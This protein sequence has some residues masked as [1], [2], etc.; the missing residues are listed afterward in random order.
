M[1]KYVFVSQQGSDQCGRTLTLGLKARP[2]E[3]FPAHNSGCPKVLFTSWLTILPHNRV[4]A[5]PSHYTR[6]RV[7]S[8]DFKLTFIK[9]EP[10]KLAPGYSSS[11]GRKEASLNQ[12][13]VQC[14]QDAH[15]ERFSLFS[16]SHD[17]ATSE[18]LLYK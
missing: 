16:V 7:K 13:I 8:Q 14:G 4:V 10:L 15:S 12:A 6:F 3:R 1:H 18:L 2:M 11:L 17:T 9:R 5:C